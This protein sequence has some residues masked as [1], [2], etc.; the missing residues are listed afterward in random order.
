[1]QELNLGEKITYK[2]TTTKYGRAYFTIGVKREQ[3]GVIT[4]LHII[5]DQ[6]PNEETQ[7]YV[8][9]PENQHTAF[10]IG[11]YPMKLEPP[12][13]STTVYCEKHDLVEQHWAVPRH[14]NFLEVKE[15]GSGIQIEFRGD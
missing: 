6:Q 15:Y 5:R 2:H 4:E 1:M 8:Y 12:T 9:K 3:Y 14:S 10:N 13:Q 11:R 7:H